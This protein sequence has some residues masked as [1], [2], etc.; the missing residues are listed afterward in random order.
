[1]PARI[2]RRLIRSLDA[3]GVIGVFCVLMVLPSGVTRLADSDTIVP[4]TVHI[5]PGTHDW[6]YVM[7]ALRYSFTFLAGNRRI[8]SGR[9]SLR[10]GARGRRASRLGGRGARGA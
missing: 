7:S 2:V 3:A 8:P 9:R 5:Q 10:P 4:V 1:M 6:T